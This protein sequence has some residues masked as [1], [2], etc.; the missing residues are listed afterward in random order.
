MECREAIAGPIKESSA[1]QLL[2]SKTKLEGLEEMEKLASDPV[3]AMEKLEK[4]QRVTSRIQDRGRELVDAQAQEKLLLNQ[5]GQVTLSEQE[6]K[7][8]VR[9]MLRREM[10]CGSYKLQTDLMTKDTVKRMESVSDA[11]QK[12][13]C[14]KC[15]L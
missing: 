15:G 3:L 14:G 13:N 12:Y 2:T 8:C 7:D 1:F 10:V 6:K 5:A 4:A 9:D 11:V